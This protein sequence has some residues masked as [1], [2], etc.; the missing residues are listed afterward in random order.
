M[1]WAIRT[2]LSVAS[3]LLVLLTAG[4]LMWFAHKD[5]ISALRVNERRGLNNVMF[6]L[7]R[8][9]ASAHADVLHARIAAVEN[10]KS[11]LKSAAD[12]AFSVADRAPSLGMDAATVA[13]VLNAARTDVSARVR[14]FRK[15][16]EGAWSE[17]GSDAPPPARAGVLFPVLAFGEGEFVLDEGASGDLWTLSF[18]ARRGDAGVICSRRPAAAAF[19]RAGIDAAGERFTSLLSRVS[20]QET[21]FAAVLDDSGE[22]VAGPP[23]VLIP[24]KLKET[25]AAGTFSGVS[26]RVMVLP[27]GDAEDSPKVLYLIAFFRP[28]RWHVVLAAPIDEL[29]APAVNL[30]AGQLWVTFAVT[31]GGLFVGLFLARHIAG[32][33]RRLTRVVRRLPEQDILALDVEALEKDLPGK[34]KDEVGELARSF[35][36]MAVDLRDNTARL[37]EASAARERIEKELQ[38][39]RDIQ[40]GILPQEFSGDKHV[41]LH[42]SMSTAKEVGGDLYDFFHLDERRFCFAVGDVSDKSVPAAL[43]MSMAVT[44]LRAAMRGDGLSPENAMARVNDALAKDN[45]RNM[46]VTLIIAVLDVRTGAVAWASA[47]HMPPILISGNKAE[48]LA[49]SGDVMAGAFEGV[50]FTPQHCVLAPGEALFLY[51]DGVSEAMDKDLNLFGED[52]LLKELAACGGATAKETTAAVCEAVRAHAAGEE[53]SD[54]IAVM[55]V[56]YRGP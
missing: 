5:T 45:P 23:H 41:E 53:Q 9:L 18:V 8:D 15:T 12:A 43:F 22:V 33:I 29:E 50:S 10:L 42:A 14:F 17:A 24:A 46:F 34:R 56:R 32:P 35:G 26:R 36:R 37:L 11:E 52:R 6:L 38:V 54:D 40:Y 13:E 16:A 4:S 19:S 1:F 30:V 28:L 44:L 31:A 7:E 47:G 48:S 25:L 21:G 51:T 27:S 20:V 49:V 2:R 3:I 39:A 55:A